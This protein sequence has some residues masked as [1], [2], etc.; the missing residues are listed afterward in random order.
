MA[1]S[2]EERFDYVAAAR[3]NRAIEALRL[4]S[5]CSNKRYYQFTNEKV[6]SI[7]QELEEALQ[8]AKSSFAPRSFRKVKF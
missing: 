4:L 3:A 7:F 5:K 8:S 2:P 6:D 1:K